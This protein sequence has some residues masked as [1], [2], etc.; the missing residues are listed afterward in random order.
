MRMKKMTAAAIA[1]VVGMS[2]LS[3][4]GFAS[5]A[6]SKEAARNSADMVRAVSSKGSSFD[7]GIANDEKLIALL[8]KEGKIAKHASQ[9]DA[10]KAVQ[11]YLKAKGEGAKK[12]TKDK[13]PK[14]IAGFKDSSAP[15][16][17]S[18]KSGKGNKLGQAKKNQ[19][20]PIN[21]E[22]YDGSVRKDK[23]LVL[24]IDF[25]DNPKSTIDPSE[26]DMYYPD[27]SQQHFQNMIFGKSGY[28]GPNGENLVSM[29]QFYEQQ[30]GGS[31]T[32]DGTVAGWYTA[33]HPAAYYGGNAP[34]TGSD[35]RPRQLIYEALTKAGQDPSINLSDYDVW[36]RDDYDGD[37]V[38]HEPD[39][40]IDHLMVIHSGVGEEAGGGKLGADAI[41]SHRWNL[42]GLVAVPGGTSNSDRFGGLLGAYDYTIEPEDGA[43]GVF[44]HEFGHDL[45]L[46]DEYDTIYSGAGEPIEYWSIMS[47]G[48][49][50]GKVPGTEPSGFSPYAKQFLQNAHGGNWLSGT[51]INASDITSKGTE[52]LLDEAATKGTNNDAVRIDLPDKETEVNIPASGSYEYFS[53]SGDELDQSMTKTIDLTHA[54][55]AKLT[56]KTWYTIEQDWDYA[57]VQVNGKSIPGNI[58]TTSDPNQQSPG[59]GITGD[60]KGWIDAT[61]D[62]SAYAGQKIEL[63]LNYWTD[64]AVALPGFYVDDLKVTADG[65][66]IVADDAE[67]TPAFTLNGFKKDTGK[68]HS[69]NYYLL[70]WRTHSGVDEGLAHIRRGASLM[71]YDPG[72]VVWYVDDSYSE[73][74]TGVHPGDGYLGLVDADQRINRW[75]NGNLGGTRYQLNDAAFSLDKS[76]KMFLDYT[77]ID[78]STLKDNFTKRNPLF[79]D[80]ADYTSDVLPDAGRN[81]PTNGLKFRVVGQSPNGTVGKVLLYK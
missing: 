43:A 52:V 25:P 49:W 22:N 77:S 21:K 58:T 51:T 2:S 71:S 46:P 34:E 35:Q 40:I 79:D 30:S 23:V 75:S 53:G 27:Y 24:A 1:A 28:T 48:S 8:K 12:G 16:K 42:G 19:V 72:L 64:V 73:N 26:T 78:G 39:G 4:F 61:F 80:S 5:P 29:K 31:Y 55:D 44:A 10:E 36:D 57:S 11:K 54:S 68:F 70:E 69:K 41:W 45:G 63:S 13:L 9:S 37:G 33:D 7:A 20:D 67:G 65:E 50:A 15:V 18:L 60:S 17:D 62:L 56:F 81:I 74:W 14:G 47:A 76:S 59:N 6:T 3:L 66:Q 38:Y 32:V